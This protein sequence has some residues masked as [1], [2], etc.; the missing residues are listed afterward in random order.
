ME[1]HE[2]LA[3]L[4]RS[5]RMPRSAIVEAL[6]GS[7]DPRLATSKATVGRWFNGESE[8]SIHQICF[9]CRLFGTTIGSYC[10]E[11]GEE[12]VGPDD[13]R[14]RT[15]DES[16]IVTIVQRVGPERALRRLLGIESVGGD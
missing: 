12:G 13:A 8:P 14:P 3:A 2:R 11:S 10:P 6:N 1:F 9:L 15:Q 16:L 5:R 4:C 7:G